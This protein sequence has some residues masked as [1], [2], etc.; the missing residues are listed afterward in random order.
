MATLVVLPSYNERENIVPL[1]SAIL[2]ID[3]SY[4]ACVVDD[5]SPDGTADAVRAFIAGASP[6]D[7]S[8]VYL[9]VRAKKD[10][11]GQA[12]RTGIEWGLSAADRPTFDAF[13]EMDCDFSHPPDDIPR[14]LGLLA[15]SDVAMG[16][17][18]PDGKIVGWPFRRRAF[19]FLANLLARMLIR[20]EIYDYTN[21]FRFY[22]RRAAE[23]MCQRP[24]RHKGYIYLSETIAEF[25][26]RDMKIACFPIVF[27][28]RERGVSNTSLREIRSALFGIFDVA[29]RYR[30]VRGSEQ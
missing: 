16:C 24:Q 12:V 28:N 17:R 7:A 1:L 23:L 18:Y 27:V 9:I 4:H 6:T 10:G 26:K 30:F 2:A 5:S 3:A 19:S 13:V 20:W 22:S 8:R 14:G 21:G 25:L 11:R 29:W 15:D